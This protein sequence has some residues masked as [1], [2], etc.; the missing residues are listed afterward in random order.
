[1]NERTIHRDYKLNR[2]DLSGFPLITVI[3]N[4]EEISQCF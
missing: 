1:M 4:Q 2:V 3:M